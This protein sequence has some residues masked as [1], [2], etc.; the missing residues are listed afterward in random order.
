MFNRINSTRTCRRC[1]KDLEPRACFNC[2]GEGRTS[3]L[4]FFKKDCDVC[5]GSGTVWR[6]PDEFKAAHINLLS[7]TGSRITSSL[8]L[9]QPLQPLGKKTKPLVPTP[10]PPWDAR[11]PNVLNPMHPRSPYNPNNP[12]SPLNPSNPRNPNNPMN[13]NSPMNPNNKPF[14][15]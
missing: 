11:N 8:N 13:P 7:Y 6:C 9:K 12:N 14:K 1:G 4:L 15:K 10:L 3:F 5:G 2:S